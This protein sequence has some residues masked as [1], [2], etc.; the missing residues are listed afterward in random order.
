ARRGGGTRAG[1]ALGRGE[2]ARHDLRL[3]HGGD[4]LAPGRPLIGPDRVRQAAPAHVI[5]FQQAIPVDGLQVAGPRERESEDHHGAAWYCSVGG[6]PLAKPEL[7]PC[8]YSHSVMTI[9]STPPAM[10]APARNGS[11]IE[12][13]ITKARA[14]TQPTG[15]HCMRVGAR[16]SGVNSAVRALVA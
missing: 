11:V 14:S 6:P 13:V 4:R 15:T 16:P 10:N 12:A 3:R 8:R 7:R 1:A 5:A 9:S 2:G